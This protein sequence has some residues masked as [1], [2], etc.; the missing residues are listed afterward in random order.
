M[1][2]RS[3]NEARAT[4]TWIKIVAPRMSEDRATEAAHGYP[5]SDLSSARRAGLHDGAR[6]QA[7]SGRAD[8]SSDLGTQRHRH[9]ALAVHGGAGSAAARPHLAGVEGA[10]A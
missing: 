8:R 1:H 4:L 10:V 9:P 3:P 2:R 6:R 5:G 7:R